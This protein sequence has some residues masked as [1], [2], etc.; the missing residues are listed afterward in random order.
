MALMRSIDDVK[1]E[2][3]K[4]A[5]ERADELANKKYGSTLSEINRW[6]KS[7]DPF[8]RALIDCTQRWGREGWYRAKFRPSNPKHLERAVMERRIEERGN[9]FWIRT[10]VPPAELC[11]KIDEYDTYHRDVVNQEY[12]RLV[13]KLSSTWRRILA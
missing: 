10:A 7:L 5:R 1:R 9:D 6:Y 4:Q 13:E 2:A 12:E 11:D 8:E 3:L